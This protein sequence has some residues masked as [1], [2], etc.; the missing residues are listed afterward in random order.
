MVDV[1]RER[2]WT[3][4]INRAPGFDNPEVYHPRWARHPRFMAMSGPYDQGGANQ[5]RSG[6]TQAEIWL[7]RFSGDFT[8]VEAWARV[9]SNAGG[10]S[11]PDVWIDRAQSPHPHA[12]E[13]SRR[14]R[15]AAAATSRAEAAPDRVVVEARL[16]SAGAV[17]T[18]ESIAPYRHALVVSRYEIVKVVEGTGRQADRRGAVGDSR[19]AGAARRAARPSATVHR[20]TLERYEAHPG[21]RRRAIDPGRRRRRLPLYYEVDRSRSP[22]T[23]GLQLLSLPLLLPAAG[24]AAVLRVAPAAK[25]L[26]LTVLSYVF[27]GWANP[28]FVLLLLFS[29]LID[30]VVRACISP[31]CARNAASTPSQGDRACPAGA[32]RLDVHQSDAARLLQVFQ[33]RRRQHQRVWRMAI[34]SRCA[35]ARHRTA[36][37]AAARHQLLHV[38][39]DELR[40]RRLSRRRHAPCAASSTSPA[41]WRCSRN[42]W[43]GRSSASRRWPTSCARARTRRRSSRAASRSSRVGLAKKVLLANPCG[44]VADLAFDAGSLAPA[45]RLVRRDGLRVPDLLR[46]QRLLRHG[47]R[48]RAD[49]RLR[50]P[51]ELRSPYLSQSI[52]EFWRRWHISL[53]TWLRDYLYVPLGGNRKGPVRTYVNLFIVMLLGGL[54]HGASW[55]FVDLGRPARRLARLRAHA[56][57]GGAVLAAARRRCGSR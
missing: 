15:A 6:G 5:V 32:H 14:A 7:G 22:A 29:T 50:V 3:V 2:R 35:A 38:P 26:V 23:H 51:E 56:R 45:R 17:P 42:W 19:R 30:Y 13:R 9:T 18:P 53:S 52:T 25:H 24:A 16:V 37:H 21:T 41:S 28:L 33:L 8:A 12:G 34:G 1:N 43:P 11:Y 4:P 10:D 39:V 57:Q 27:Y 54:W 46:L 44:K 47:D 31:M 40:H 48:P 49:A 55:N 36:R 20:L